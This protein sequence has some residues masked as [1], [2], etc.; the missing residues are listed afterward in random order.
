MKKHILVAAV[1]AVLSLSSCLTAFAG[2][3]VM[4]RFDEGGEW[5]YAKDDAE[6]Q[7]CR[8]ADGNTPDWEEIDG[9]WY[10]FDE[11]GRMYRDEFTPEGYW[12]DRNGA[13]VA[14]GPEE[15]YA[16]EMDRREREIKRQDSYDYEFYIQDMNND[17]TPELI[18]ISGSSPSTSGAQI[19][20]YRNGA[21]VTIGNVNGSGTYYGLTDNNYITSSVVGISSHSETEYF[22]LNENNQIEFADRLVWVSGAYSKNGHAT[23]YRADSSFD[24]DT[25]HIEDYAEEISE[26]ESEELSREY[27]NGSQTPVRSGSL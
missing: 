24:G 2:H 20:T 4:G 8:A 18:E 10:A 19:W 5:F 17:G 26:S 16:H 27:G 14:C 12:V 9:V 11:L 23:Y 15:L 25:D 21:L 13:Y 1:A 7:F 22:R 3:W 6:T